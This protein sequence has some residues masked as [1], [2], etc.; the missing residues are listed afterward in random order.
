MYEGLIGLGFEEDDI[1]V[2]WEPTHKE[3]E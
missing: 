3:M 2:A 1:V